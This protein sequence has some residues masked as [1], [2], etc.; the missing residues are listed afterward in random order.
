MYKTT[1]K[2]TV[3]GDKVAH[4]KPQKFDVSID[5]HALFHYFRIRKRCMEIYRNVEF[6]R[7]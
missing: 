6:L 7:F 5:F 2:R 1:F 4:L 3:I